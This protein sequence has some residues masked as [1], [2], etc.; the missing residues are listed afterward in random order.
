MEKQ[1]NRN[2]SATGTTTAFFL[3][4]PLLTYIILFYGTTNILYPNESNDDNNTS[5]S[6]S[7][8]GGGGEEHEVNV[9]I[10]NATDIIESMKNVKNIS[11]TATATTETTRIIT[12][13]QPSC[14]ISYLNQI[15]SDILDDLYVD[16]TMC[17]PKDVTNLKKHR[18]PKVASKTNKTTEPRAMMVV[19]IAVGLLL[20][21]LGAAI[22][23]L[24]K[25]KGQSSV[26]TKPT[27]TRK[28]SL[29]DLTVLKHNRK[30][31]MR[32]DTMWDIP[33]GRKSSEQFGMK[34]S[35]PPLRL[36]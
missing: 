28:C 15:L 31:L 30:E 18:L 22:V 3:T 9:S 34:M 29:A 8:G 13:K 33:E 27:L 1:N 21:S 23:E 36:D 26:K 12:I 14:T 17:T 16:R 35:R 20:T 10:E 7:D 24:Y 2:W 6:S 4:I 25:A 32:R 11:T 19:Y 5:S